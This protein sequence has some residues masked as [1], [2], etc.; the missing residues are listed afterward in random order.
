MSD[1]TLQTENDGD[2]RLE[3]NTRVLKDGPQITIISLSKS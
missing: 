2:T 1:T 3:Y